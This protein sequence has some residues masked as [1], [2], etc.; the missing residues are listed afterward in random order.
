MKLHFYLATNNVNKINEVRQIMKIAG[1]EVFPSPSNIDFPEEKGKTFEENALA[2]AKYLKKYLPLESVAGED[3]G[4]EVESLGGLPGIHSARFAGQH[5]DNTKNIKKLLDSLLIYKN[6]NERKAKF[7]S[8]IA[9]IDSNGIR[10]F[11]GEVE[12]FITFSP[13][14]NNG[15][16]YDPVFETQ[17]SGKT[18]AELSME[19]KNKISHRAD[20]F[21]KLSLYLLTREGKR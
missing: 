20:A 9:F 3:S 14:G 10:F 21:K 4:L 19:E 16:G 13:R 15:F 6:V 18:F 11:R 1:I 5:G 2:K 8:V 12:G 7:I 17:E